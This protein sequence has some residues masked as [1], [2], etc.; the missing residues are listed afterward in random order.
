MINF[1]LEIDVKSTA[2]EEGIDSSFREVFN[3]EN[4][5]VSLSE[6]VQDIDLLFQKEFGQSKKLFFNIEID[7]DSLV[8]DHDFR[9]RFGIYSF[10]IFCEDVNIGN[11][12][13]EFKDLFDHQKLN[14]N[15][16]ILNNLKPRIEDDNIFNEVVE[17]EELEELFPFRIELCED[18][19]VFDYDFRKH[20]NIHNFETILDRD[21][22]V[23]DLSFEEYFQV[24]LLPKCDVIVNP[25]NNLSF[26]IELDEQSSVFDYDF[27]KRFG[28]KTFN[29]FCK[30]TDIGNIN[31]EF[32][33][34]F[35][36]EKLNSPLNVDILN[37]LKPLIVNDVVETFQEVVEVQTVEEVVEQVQEVIEVETVQEV[38][39]VPEEIA[40][41]VETVEEQEEF[42]FGI[43]LC[44]DGLVF[45]YDFRNH[46]NIH[47]F[48]ICLDRSKSVDDLIFEDRFKV[49]LEP[50]YDYDIIDNLKRNLNSRK[51]ITRDE[52]PENEPDVFSID[53]SKKTQ[54]SLDESLEEN[55]SVIKENSFYKIVEVNPDITQLP[56]EVD[57]SYKEEVDEK[58]SNME[59]KY[60]DLLQKTKDQ[61][62]NQMNKMA[63]E[64]ATFR[65]NIAQQVSRMAMVSTSAGGG[66]VNILDMDDVDK[67]NIQDGYTLSYNSN[68]RKFEFLDLSTVGSSATFNLMESEVFTIT[69]NDLDNSYMDLSFSADSNY[70]DISEFHINGLVNIHQTNYTFTTSSRI[71]ISNL[72]LEIGDIVR[73]VYIKS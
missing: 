38:V 55:K 31:E 17:V 27:R 28:I 48:K 24:N 47:N 51:I 54:L 29:I 43:E 60:E 37:N 3:I 2:L 10:N 12:N 25:K 40:Q 5:S 70:Y 67:T 36:D 4:F 68:T 46:F 44:K 26:N 73:I 30:N 52:V 72:S 71:D 11:P 56:T 35:Y 61:Y 22:T 16:D 7:S 57:T 8:Y 59:S 32:N 19:T 69:Q 33:D 1:D 41:E 63:E 39:E 65:N 14:S 6:Q 45:D 53:K 18:G 42:P 20:F 15:V 66:A 9:K 64:F 21:K 23:N 62:Q 13:Q 58:L 50:I 49:D 34:L